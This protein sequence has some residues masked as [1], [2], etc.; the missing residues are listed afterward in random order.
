MENMCL[1]PTKTD[2]VVETIERSKQVAR[3]CSQEDTIVHYDLAIAKIAKTI[4]V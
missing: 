2:V 3:D 4:Q 1:P